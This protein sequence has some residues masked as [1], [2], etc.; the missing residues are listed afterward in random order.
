MKFKKSHIIIALAVCAAMA[1][2]AM[3]LGFASWQTAISA[4]GSVT[5]NGKWDLAITDADM[6]IS[7]VGAEAKLDYSE[8]HLN[9]KDLTATQYGNLCISA[10]VPRESYSSSAVRGQQNTT[11]GLDKN[12]NCYL[13]LVDSTRIDI[14][15]FGHITTNNDDGRAA[16]FR[17]LADKTDSNAAI[18]RLWDT[19][20]ATDGQKIA[21]LKAWNYYKGKTDYFGDTSVQGK[22]AEDLI[23]KSDELIRELRPNTYQNYVLVDFACNQSTDATKD[24]SDVQFIIAE[25]GSVDGTAP[26][27]ATYTDFTATFSDVSFTL[28]GAWAEYNVTVTNRGTVNANLSGLDINLDTESEQLVLDKP[29]LSGEILKPGESCTVKCV[30]KVPSEITE[31]LNASGELNINLTYGQNNIEP[32]PAAGHSHK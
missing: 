5:A 31:E 14:T 30:V 13:C 25:M 16:M 11:I 27:S 17:T 7:S 2:S 29:D 24:Q 3:S 4:N 12:Q 10:A 15:R 20:T 6:S 8:F 26:K 28:P 22:I 32:A 21:P 1:I 18:I 23:L 9:A 19:N